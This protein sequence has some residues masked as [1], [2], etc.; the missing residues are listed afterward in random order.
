MKKKLSMMLLAF[1][2][3]VTS[4]TAI[5]LV[6]NKAEAKDW[7]K[8]GQIW[9]TYYH[10]GSFKN[11]TYSP[12]FH[13]YYPGQGT[14]ANIKANGSG[15]GK[16][17]ATLQQKTNKGWKNVKTFYATKKGSTNLSYKQASKSYKTTYRFKFTNTGTKKTIS[18]TFWATY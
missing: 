7:V 14:W 13:I 16:I 15:S 5:D 4:F 1:V 17:T 10:S 6:N 12:T 18:Y 3:A 11:Y 2:V 8:K 9:S